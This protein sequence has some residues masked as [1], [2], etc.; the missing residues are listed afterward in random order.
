MAPLRTRSPPP[1]DQT[2]GSGT[3]MP[4]SSNPARISTSPFARV[5]V[6]GYQRPRRIG[7]DRVQLDRSGAK[8]TISGLPSP[9]VLLCIPPATNR[10]PSARNECPEQKTS[11]GSGAEVEFPVAGS[12]IA[13]SRST[14]QVNTF[15]LGSRLTCTPIT[16]QAN[17]ADHRPIEDS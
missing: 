15:P 2:S 9:T 4:V 11:D 1:G 10:R 17:G 3:W 6:V 13:G 5:V 8:M 7:V 14:P 16:G 12:Q